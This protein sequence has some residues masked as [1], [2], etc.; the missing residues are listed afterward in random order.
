MERKHDGIINLLEV[1]QLLF[2]CFNILCGRSRERVRK[3][4]AVLYNFFNSCHSIIDKFIG[5]IVGLFIILS[6]Y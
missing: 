1:N 5:N 3:Y 2:V 4:R 6:S